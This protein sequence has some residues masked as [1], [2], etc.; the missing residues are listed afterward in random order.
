MMKSVEDIRH[1]MN[2][3]YESFFCVL[4]DGKNQKHFNVRSMT[5]T[6]DELYC[7]SMLRE[8]HKTVRL[9]N[10]KLISYLQI[11]QNVVDCNHYLKSYN[12]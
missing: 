2:E 6:L 12:L 10:I 4:C 1:S 8:H 11:L 5:V 3:Y 7:K 9:F